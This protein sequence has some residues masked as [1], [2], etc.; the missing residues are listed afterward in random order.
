MLLISCPTAGFDS[1]IQLHIPAQV[2]GRR[3]AEHQ[4]SWRV[5]VVGVEPQPRQPV[6]EST[7]RDRGL[8][9]G[10]LRAEAEVRAL[11]EGEIEPCVG[12]TDVESRRPA[13][14]RTRPRRAAVTGRPAVTSETAATI[15]AYHDNTVSALTSRSP[16]AS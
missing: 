5:R 15:A 7:D 6:Q 1:E 14:G 10:E 3:F 13:A 12:A 4:T 9:P 8:G 2:Q 11:R 16:S